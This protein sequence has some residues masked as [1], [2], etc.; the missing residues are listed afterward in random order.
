MPYKDPKVRKERNRIYSKT[1]RAKNLDRVQEQQ[2]IAKRQEYAADPGKFAKRSKDSYEANKKVVYARIIQRRQ[3]ILDWFRDY[4]QERGVRCNICG[5]DDPICL[6]FHHLDPSH[7][8]GPITTSIRSKGWSKDRV[9]AEL[10]K[11]KILCV[12]CHRHIHNSTLSVRSY[13]R[14]VAEYKAKK[15]CSCG[16]SRSACLD[17]HHRD[18]STKVASISKLLVLG[19]LKDLWEE[20]EKCD[21]LCA[22]CHRKSHKINE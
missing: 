9:L 18:P 10:A 5:L 14:K 21:V 22:N 13:R 1:W 6:D 17:F 2:R 16:E 7:K 8:D 20:I 19:R 15:G 11:C 3:K 12:N 4:C